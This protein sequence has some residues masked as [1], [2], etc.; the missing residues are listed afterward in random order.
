VGL[1]KTTGHG[2]ASTRGSDARATRGCEHGE[3]RLTGAY[4]EEAWWA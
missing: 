1:T 3:A 4:R 2:V